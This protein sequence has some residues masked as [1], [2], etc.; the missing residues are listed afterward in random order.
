MT[1]PE[2]LR[3]RQLIE[4]AL[5]CIVIVLTCLTTWYTLEQNKKTQNCL[6][7]TVHALTDAIQTRSGLTVQSQQSTNDLLTGVT[8]LALGPPATT[9]QERAEQQRAYQELFAHFQADQQ[10]IAEQ[11]S[12]TPIPS[13]PSGKCKND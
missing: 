9:E 2:R 5:V 1:T 6:E 3:R 13:Y 12:H 11:R 10:H 4:S 8:A 7:Q